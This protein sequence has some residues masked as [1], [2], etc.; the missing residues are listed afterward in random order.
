MKSLP[1]SPLK[2]VW[3]ASGARKGGHESKVDVAKESGPR[4]AT[5][6]AV[7]QA[8]EKKVAHERKVGARVIGRGRQP[9]A[10]RKSR[11]SCGV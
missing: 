9:K 7:K 4:R 1:K 11:P 2:H 3:K 6:N 8:V 10:T 5:G